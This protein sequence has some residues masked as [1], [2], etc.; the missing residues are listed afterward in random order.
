MNIRTSFSPF[1]FTQKSHNFTTIVN[2][3]KIILRQ[4]KMLSSP[5]IRKI[6][7]LLEI[8]P[9]F[10]YIDEITIKFWYN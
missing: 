4:L 2:Y 9:L 3:N 8:I 10:F 6:G 7:N 1:I 5:I